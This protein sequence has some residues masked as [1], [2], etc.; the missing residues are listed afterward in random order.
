MLIRINATYISYPALPSVSCRAFSDF[1]TPWPFIEAVHYDQP[2]LRV[3][4]DIPL[5][6]ATDV[7]GPPRSLTMRIHWRALQYDSPEVKTALLARYS[8]TGLV[9]GSV[10]PTDMDVRTATSTLDLETYL[11]PKTTYTICLAPFRGFEIYVKDKHPHRFIEWRAYWLHLG[12]ER[13]AR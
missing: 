2:P 5:E 6:I 13:C 12:V 1:G 9:P 4:C 3:E 7:T 10:W 11:V 8:K